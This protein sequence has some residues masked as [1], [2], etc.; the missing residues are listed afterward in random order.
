MRES[1]QRRRDRVTQRE[2][3]TWTEK[4]TR[5]WGWGGLPDVGEVPDGMKAAGVP[6]GELW[7]V[8]AGA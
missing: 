1:V 4:D 8:G 3:E 7:G 6:G 2:A 5:V